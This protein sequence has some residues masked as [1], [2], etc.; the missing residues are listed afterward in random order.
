MLFLNAPENEEEQ[1]LGDYYLNN[2]LGRGN[3]GKV[4]SA[5][6][7]GSDKFVAIKVLEPDKNGQIKPEGVGEFY[8]EVEIMASLNHEH[9]MPLR[10]FGCKGRVPF[11]V[12]KLMSGGTLKGK[13]LFQRAQLVKTMEQI[14]SG[15]Q[16]LQENGLIHQDLKPAN[17]LL[18]HNG[19]ATISDF[20]VAVKAGTKEAEGCWGT[21]RYKAPEQWEGK[22]CLQSDVYALGLIAFEL[23]T[24]RNLI[25]CMIDDREYR[26]VY[27]D[28]KANWMNENKERYNNDDMLKEQWEIHDHYRCL[29]ERASEWLEEKGF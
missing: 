5:L 11:L 14:C 10:G 15:V 17:I 24:G 7:L 19:N 16:Y 18:E 8:R 4:F 6:N 12:T 23:L 20:G 1:W 28:K 13:R 21:P 29:H 25:G 26:K 2:E 27:E 3:C 9:V 22:A